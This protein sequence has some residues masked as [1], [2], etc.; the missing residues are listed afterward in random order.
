MFLDARVFLLIQVKRRHIVFERHKSKLLFC[1]DTRHR[2]PLLRRGCNP[3]CQEQ[4]APFPLG[5]DE[6]LENLLECADGHS[7][8]FSALLLH[9]VTSRCSR[10][11]RQFL[12]SLIACLTAGRLHRFKA[13]W[14]K[15]EAPCWLFEFA[16]SRIKTVMHAND[17]SWGRIFP[18]LSVVPLSRSF[19]FLITSTILVKKVQRELLGIESLSSAEPTEGSESSENESVSDD[20]MKEWR[21]QILPPFFHQMD[22]IRS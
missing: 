6:H 7:L 3:N 4:V 21:E 18:H 19:C 5:L 13:L 14:A 16:M 8:H 17:F 1:G 22:R 11:T 9:T 15:P 20:W 2:L 12:P 10:G